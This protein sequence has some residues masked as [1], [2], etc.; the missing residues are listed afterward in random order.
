MKRVDFQLR[1][2]GRAAAAGD[3]LPVTITSDTAA[4]GNRDWFAGQAPGVA[5]LFPG[6]DHN[7]RAPAIRVVD[8]DTAGPA[9][10]ADGERT[11]ERPARLRRHRYRP[12]RRDRHLALER[13]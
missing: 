11:A 1:P 5:M 10:R 6:V 9:R 3:A 2:T 4:A 8:L 12:Q 7:P 13:R